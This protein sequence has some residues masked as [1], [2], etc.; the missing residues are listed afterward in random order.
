MDDY[1]PLK[2]TIF[3]I[4]YISDEGIT[5]E[6]IPAALEG[7]FEDMLGGSRFI[8]EETGK[9]PEDIFNIGMALEVSEKYLEKVW[10]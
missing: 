4:L 10:D 5:I 9:T 1:L 2:G 7:E 3:S 8:L 6:H